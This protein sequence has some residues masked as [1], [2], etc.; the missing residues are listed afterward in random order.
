M[1]SQPLLLY[2]NFPIYSGMAGGEL[3]CLFY[4]GKQKHNLRDLR[5]TAGV[6]ADWLNG[7][8]EPISCLA[9]STYNNIDIAL[10]LTWYIRLYL[11]Y[12]VHIYLDCG[13][14]QCGCNALDDTTYHHEKH[15][16]HHI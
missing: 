16:G 9:C 5:F 14:N 11:D 3:H 4:G 10:R 13:C 2:A 8:V 7:S 1:W 12:L 6:K 15:S